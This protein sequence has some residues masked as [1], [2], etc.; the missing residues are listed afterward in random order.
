MAPAASGSRTCSQHG[1]GGIG[2][3]RVVMLFLKLGNVRWASLIPRD[4][5]S[6]NKPGLDPQEASAASANAAVLKGPEATTF[7][8]GKSKGKMPPL[9]DVRY[10]VSICSESR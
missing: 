4:P 3:E 6:F 1:G 2:L 5:R 10:V 7:Q 9:E 8:Q